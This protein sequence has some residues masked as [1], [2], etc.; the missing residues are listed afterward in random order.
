MSIIGGCCILEQ[1]EVECNRDLKPDLKVSQTKNAAQDAAG[2]R[3]KHRHVPVEAGTVEK[4][5]PEARVSPSRVKS[6]P[7]KLTNMESVLALTTATVSAFALAFLNS[8]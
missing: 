1:D 2:E 3:R 6:E 4:R 7:F 8:A 5:L